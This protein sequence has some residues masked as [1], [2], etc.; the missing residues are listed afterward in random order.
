MKKVEKKVEKELEKIFSEKV[1]A[2][3]Y[4]LASDVEANT[5]LTEVRERGWVPFYFDGQA[6]TD[7]ES[8][9][10]MAAAAMS[11]PSYFGNNWDAFEECVTDLE[12]IEE[13][14]RV[15]LYDHASHFIKQSPKEWKTASSI[16]GDAVEESKGGRAPLYI[17]LRHAAAYGE[18]FPQV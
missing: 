17:L 2:G 4:R 3:V 14:P 1:E 10:R 9:F 16:L 5:L 8:F 6:I 11:F 18:N 13:R 7:K 15:L 12:W